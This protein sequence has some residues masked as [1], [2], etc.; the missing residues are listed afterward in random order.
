M[1]APLEPAVT[2]S[3]GSLLRQYRVA[4]GLTQEELAER[5]E[6]SVRGLRYLERDLRRPYRDTAR[7]AGF[8]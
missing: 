4:I 5:A 7:R 8:P 2:A 1:N 3:F 6:L